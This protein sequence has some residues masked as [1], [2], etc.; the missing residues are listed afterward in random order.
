MSEFPILPKPYRREE[1]ALHIRAAL[2]DPVV[3]R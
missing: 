3:L 1:L 2:G